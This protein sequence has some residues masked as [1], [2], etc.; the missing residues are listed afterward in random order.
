MKKLLILV[1]AFGVTMSITSCAT[2]SP[3]TCYARKIGNH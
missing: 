2:V 3:H 1:L